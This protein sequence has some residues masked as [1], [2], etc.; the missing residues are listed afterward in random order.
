MARIFLTSLISA[1]LALPAWSQ[2]IT[3]NTELRAQGSPKGR[4]I[5]SLKGN[6]K[7]DRVLKVGNHWVRVRVGSREGWVSK[8]SI[9]L[10]RSQTEAALCQDCSQNTS[11]SIGSQAKE[12]QS[13]AVN[14][15]VT[16]SI[17]KFMEASYKR[18][19]QCRP[20]SKTVRR[21]TGVSKLCGNRS[22]GACY[23]GVKDAIADVYG[24]PRL[25]GI[26]AVSAHT[27][28]TLKKKGFRNVTS[29]YK[30]AGNAPPGAVLV[31]SGGASGHIETV[32]IRD[33]KRLYCSD[34]C[35]SSPI[36][37]RASRKLVGIYYPPR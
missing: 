26:H 7:V 17:Q 18:A 4:V 5:T 31:Y 34:F 16:P 28:G 2:V 15:S 24:G 12:I 30:T 37:T 6:T 23:A 25:E 8:Q 35:S 11:S 33:G 20:T 9:S 27:N 10:N 29:Q 13:A 21:R 19:T 3:Q 32:V 36:N 22:K 14:A 1:F